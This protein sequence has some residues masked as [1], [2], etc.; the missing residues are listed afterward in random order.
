MIRFTVGVTAEALS[1]KELKWEVDLQ[2]SGTRKLLNE[3]HGMSNYY[4][5]LSSNYSTFDYFDQCYKE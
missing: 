1:L 2:S 4:S 5:L 3:T